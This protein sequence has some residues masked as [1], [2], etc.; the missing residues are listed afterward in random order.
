MSIISWGLGDVCCGDD[1]D[2]DDNDEKEEKKWDIK[3]PKAIPHNHMASG[4]AIPRSWRVASW[5]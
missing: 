3:S 2:D 1:D 5:R 4:Q